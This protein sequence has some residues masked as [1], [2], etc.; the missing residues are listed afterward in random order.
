VND[1]IGWIAGHLGLQ[2]E[3]RYAGGARGWVGDSPFI[4]LDCARM[5]SLGWKPRLSIRQ[6]IIRTLEYLRENPWVLEAR[7]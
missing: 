7:G 5:R 3:L 1:S 4:F 6:G 2:P